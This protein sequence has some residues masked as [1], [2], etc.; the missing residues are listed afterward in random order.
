MQREV[1]EVLFERSK[2][3]SCENFNELTNV[4]I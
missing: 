3:N 4:M 1:R 2:V